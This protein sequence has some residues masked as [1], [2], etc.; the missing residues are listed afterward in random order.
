MENINIFS[1]LGKIKDNWIANYY[2][3]NTNMNKEQLIEFL[4]CDYEMRFH[5]HNLKQITLYE[6]SAYTNNNNYKIIYIE[7]PSYI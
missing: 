5:N 3:I 4:R 6:A 1:L 7:K 2:I